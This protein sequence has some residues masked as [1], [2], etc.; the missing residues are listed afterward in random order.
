VR[1]TSLEAGPQEHRKAIKERSKLC[2]S[3][4]FEPRNHIL[5]RPENEK[6]A[7]VLE[8]FEFGANSWL[9]FLLWLAS[10]LFFSWL[11]SGDW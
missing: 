7:C 9:L 10:G 5:C 2:N 3:A 11:T 4:I 1:R 8:W 6:Y